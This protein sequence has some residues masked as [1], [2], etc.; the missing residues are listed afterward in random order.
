MDVEDFRS[1]LLQEWRIMIGSGLQSLR[2]EVFRVGHIGKAASA[3]YS[4]LFLEGA[5]AYLNL[6]GYRVPAA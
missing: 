3:E 5:E 2:G 4:E 6:Q 1:Y